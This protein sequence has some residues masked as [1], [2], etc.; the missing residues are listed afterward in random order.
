MLLNIYFRARGSR[1]GEGS[2]VQCGDSSP[3]PCYGF[4]DFV[5]RSNGKIL[6]AEETTIVICEFFY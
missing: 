5:S 6:K 4:G 2:S 1:F 3:Y